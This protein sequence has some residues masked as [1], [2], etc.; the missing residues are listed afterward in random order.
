MNCDNFLKTII[1]IRKFSNLQ[2]Q[3]FVM[4]ASNST[5]MAKIPAIALSEDALFLI[6][7]LPDTRIPTALMSSHPLA[8]RIRD[9]IKEMLS[10]SQGVTKISD[11]SGVGI[12]ELA[13]TIGHIV[14]DEVS[15]YRGLTEY[16][17]EATSKLISPNEKGLMVACNLDL[18]STIKLLEAGELTISTTL[19]KGPSS[20]ES[21]DI[22]PKGD[23]TRAITGSEKSALL[24]SISPTHSKENASEQ[25]VSV[26]QKKKVSQDS[27]GTSSTGKSPEAA[28][29]NSK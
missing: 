4:S 28:T 7:Y 19:S 9:A 22:T 2:G 14:E 12:K 27:K 10:K 24:A 3:H 11:L 23:N 17:W 18:A 25:S 20:H 8:T 5:T 26:Q 29:E 21:V 6:P 16:Q 15:H 1:T 13:N